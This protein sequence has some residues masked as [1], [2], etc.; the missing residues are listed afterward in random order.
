MPSFILP[1]NKQEDIVLK[2]YVQHVFEDED[3]WIVIAFVE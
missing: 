2:G 3:E 1:K